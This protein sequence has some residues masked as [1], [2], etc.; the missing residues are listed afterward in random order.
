M[1]EVRVPA[2]SANIGPGFDCLGLAL[3]LYNYFY[4]EE[5][6]S[7]LEILG[8]EDI[9]RNRDNL[10]Y[11]SMLRCFEKTGYS[12]KGLRIKIQSEIPVSRGLGSSA[13]CILAGVLAANELGNGNLSKEE[14]L[15]LA[16]EIEGHPDN[17]AP[18]LFGG[19]TVAIKDGERVYHE[20][21][22]LASG[23]KFCAL[24]PDFTLSTRDSRAVLPDNIPFKD[25]VFNVGRVSLLIAALGNGN[26]QVLNSACRDKLHEIYRSPLINNFNEITERARLLGSLCI[27][28]SGAGPTIMAI[29]KK[30]NIDFKNNMES[31]LSYLDDKWTAVE[32]EVD[33][34]GALIKKI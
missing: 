18:A 5:I 7:G 23:L 8:C 31:Y 21:L 27:F 16:A 26:F 11:K 32:L 29:I 2:T 15:E 28:L 4:I 13:S 30:D 22:P 3:G 6:E 34:E 19:I 25:G 1:I 9:F 24:I 12:C 33:F 20:R 10:V 17:I 14:I